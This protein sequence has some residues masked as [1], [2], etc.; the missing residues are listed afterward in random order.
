MMEY[1]DSIEYITNLL[2]LLIAF[3]I[4]DS[5]GNFCKPRGFWGYTIMIIVWFASYFF[6]LEVAKYFSF[7]ELP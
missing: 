7:K 1:F 6:F 2:K 5:Y 4:I 3:L